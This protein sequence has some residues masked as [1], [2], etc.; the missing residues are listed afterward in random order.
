M[1]TKEGVGFKEVM[2]TLLFVSRFLLTKVP[3][4]RARR[5]NAD[6]GLQEASRKRLQNH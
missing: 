4:S 3:E 6:D 5:E 1:A 2:M